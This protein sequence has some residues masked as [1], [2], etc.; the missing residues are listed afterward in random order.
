M[1]HDDASSVDALAAAFRQGAG[2]A[3]AD[4]G[5]GE[6]AHEGHEGHEGGTSTSV[7]AFAYR[8]HRVRIE[9]TYRVTIDDRP[10]RG[11]LEVLPS[12]AVHYHVFPQYA[13]QS[14]VDVV[15]TVI[16][17]V[18]DRPAVADEL[19]GPDPAPPGEP[20]APHQHGGHG[21]HGR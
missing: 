15:K 3:P 2:L 9:T 6:H 5:L 12:G 19:A 21:E 1:D 14:A 4:G 11:H 16:D 10:L 18:W 13:P 17:T 7:R 8:D 20:D